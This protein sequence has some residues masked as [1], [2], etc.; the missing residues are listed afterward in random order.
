MSWDVCLFKADGYR[1][2]T[3]LP[4]GFEPLPLGSMVQV[5]EKVAHVYPTVV[6]SE[7]NSSYGLWGSYEDKSEGYSIEFQLGKKDAVEAVTLHVRGGGSVIS[8]IVALC[9]ENR[10]KAFDTTEGDFIDLNQPSSKGWED[11]QAYR[12][13]FI[14]H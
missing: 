5:K 14:E 8:K 6:W 10:W 12:D 7:P 2:I 1:S 3:E 4:K 13:R 9:K 11:F